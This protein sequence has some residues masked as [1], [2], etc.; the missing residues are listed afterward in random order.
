[1]LDMASKIFDYYSN[2][3]LE[4]CN[5]YAQRVLNDLSYIR[6][7]D[8][9]AKLWVESKV[10]YT[11]YAPEGF[12]T[13]DTIIYGAGMLIVNDF[14]YG[15][16]VRVDAKD[17]SQLKLYALGAYLKLKD[18]YQINHIRMKISQPRLDNFSEDDISPTELMDWAIN[19]VAPKAR[20]A[21]NGKGDFVA[22]DH[23]RFCR[24]KL[25]CKTY[26]DRH[27]E[28][29]KYD[30]VQPNY[31]TNAD[32]S[33]ILEVGDRL[34]EW[35]KEVQEYALK[36]AEDGQVFPG[37]KLVEGK[38]TRKLL[39]Q[40]QVINRLITQGYQERVLYE[41][42]Q[43]KG[44]TDLEKQVGKRQLDKIAG[45]LIV[46]P[47]GKPTLVPEKDRRPAINSTDK[48]VKAFSQPIGGI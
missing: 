39:D 15:K 42:P 46:K 3:M 1:M 26:A 8:P 21:F 16:G 34:A 38:S 20:L 19:T 12:G 27:L 5:Q 35:V 22:G 47:P 18:E 33:H 25:R 4:Y 13:A 36:S 10:F 32:I 24:A 29:F 37:Y 7:Y 43:P 6:A 17:N 14:K 11:E 48:A 28:A 9:N 44:L 23:C 30:L 40:E 41:A 2:G 31:L 45:D